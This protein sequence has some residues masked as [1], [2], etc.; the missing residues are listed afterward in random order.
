M[1]LAARLLGLTL[2]WIILWRDLSTANVL[3]GLLVA[4]LVTVLYPLASFGRPVHSVRVVPVLAFAGYFL[5]Q[6][7]A[8]NVVVA[9]AIL[10]PKHKIRTGILEIPLPGCSDL[11]TT[12]VANAVTLTPGSMTIDVRDDPRRIYVHVLHLDPIEDARPTLHRLVEL[13]MRAFTS[14]ETQ[15]QVAEACAAPRVTPVA[16]RT[17]DDTP[18]RED[19][20]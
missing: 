17:H 20:R 10:S 19:P 16:G 3:G 2:V 11:V 6:M 4:A 9:R 8:S 15:Q 7:V 14:V 1:K 18:G 5:V 13:A 12:I